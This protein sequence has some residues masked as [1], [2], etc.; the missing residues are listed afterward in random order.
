MGIISII[1]GLVSLWQSSNLFNEDLT[2]KAESLKNAS[3]DLKN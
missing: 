3:D 1:S 2:E